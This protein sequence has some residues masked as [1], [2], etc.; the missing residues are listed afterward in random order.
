MRK[1]VAEC[2][3]RIGGKFLS[4]ED[5]KLFVK[6]KRLSRDDAAHISVQLNEL[7]RNIP[8][9]KAKPNKES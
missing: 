4:K 7:Y 6:N 9:Q 5:Q 2:R 8:S 3:I 1:N